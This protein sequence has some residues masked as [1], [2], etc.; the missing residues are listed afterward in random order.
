M[1]ISWWGKG[2]WHIC[3]HHWRVH[4]EVELL[5]FP[6][7]VRNRKGR[8]IIFHHVQAKSELKT[9]RWHPGQSDLGGFQSFFNF[10]SWTQKCK[11]LH[12]YLLMWFPAI[13]STLK[14]FQICI[15]MINYS[16]LTLSN[17]YQLMGKT[18]WHICM[19]HWTLHA[20]VEF[21]RFPPDVST[22]RGEVNHLS[23]CQG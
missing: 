16:T 18:L 2:L 12:W 3:M 11:I 9:F 8:S 4:A 15:H 22:L 19:H 5:R 1:A 17:G 7:D 20:K 10:W 13:L 21:P 23:S 14:P 6:P